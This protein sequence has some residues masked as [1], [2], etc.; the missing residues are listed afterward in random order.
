VRSE[1]QGVLI[2]ISGQDADPTTIAN[3]SS[4]EVHWQRQIMDASAAT[5]ATQA[6]LHL[7][8]VIASAHEGRFLTERRSCGESDLCLWVPTGVERPPGTIYE[9]RSS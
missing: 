4:F 9:G 3:S 5:R 8:Q 6:G 7:V 2:E 1:N